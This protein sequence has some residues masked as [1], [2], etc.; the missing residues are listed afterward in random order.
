MGTIQGMPWK[1]DTPTRAKT[2]SWR[3]PDAH[4]AGALASTIEAGA[5]HYQRDRLL[6]QLIPAS[7]GD[8]EA[9][10]QRR[11]LLLIASALRHERA[12]GRSGHWTYDLNRH[13]GLIQAWRAE[14][15]KAG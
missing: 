9:M 11:V 4:A 8:I 2:L 15:G 6:P 3:S 13:I 1:Q 7:A 14:S 10:P 5:G 12:R